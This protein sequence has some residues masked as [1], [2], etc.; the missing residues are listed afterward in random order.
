MRTEKRLTL[1]GEL[2]SVQEQGKGRQWL[3]SIGAV[4]VCI[5]QCQIKVNGYF[6]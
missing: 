4:I 6:H 3:M 2:Y 1:E 5:T